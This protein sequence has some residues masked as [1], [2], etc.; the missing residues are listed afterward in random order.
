MYQDK[1]TY[2]KRFLYFVILAFGIAIFSIHMHEAG[3]LIAHDLKGI[4]AHAEIR[5]FSGVIVHPETRHLDNWLTFASGGLGAGIFILF[6]FWLPAFLTPTIKDTYLEFSS[7]IVAWLQFI[8][9]WLEVR[10]YGSWWWFVPLTLTIIL[11][12]FFL[13]IYIKKFFRYLYDFNLIR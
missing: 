6:F 8:Y 2:I 3:H 7:F 10:N 11:F 9:A 1:I 4:D 12:I 5:Y 13:L